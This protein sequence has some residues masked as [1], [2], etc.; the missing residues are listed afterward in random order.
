MSATNRGNDRAEADFY[1]TPAYAVHALLDRIGS[2]LYA[3]KWLE[4]AAGEGNI[5][6]AFDT[7]FGQ[8]KINGSFLHNFGH[9]FSAVELREECR[10]SLE[11][12]TEE[13][14]ITDFLKA[15]FGD[16]RWEGII[17][18][19]PFTTAEQFIYRAKTLAPIVIML[20]RI[21]FLGTVERRSFWRHVGIPA[22]YVITPRPFPDAT[23]YAWFVWGLGNE[24]TLHI[25]E[26][27]R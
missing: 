7:H 19:P 27:T 3:Q 25:L 20:Q 9:S 22:A 23:E 16:R 1:P 11:H 2:E 10:T 15:D 24:G 14:I 17:T 6:A 13:V 8:Q 18:N 12:Y 4:P 5:I 26:G 21:G